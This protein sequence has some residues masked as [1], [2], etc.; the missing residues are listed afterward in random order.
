MNK[1]GD[2]IKF[3]VKEQGI[4]EAELSRRIGIAKPIINR[5]SNGINVNP[6]LETLMAIAGYFNITISQLL[7]QEPIK[8]KLNSSYSSA[9]RRKKKVPLISWADAAKLTSKKAISASDEY[10]LTESDV[11]GPLFALIAQGTAMEPRFPAKT[12]LIFST[13][14][15]LIDGGYVLV[16]LNNRKLPVFKQII[17]DGSNYFITSTNPALDDTAPLSNKDKIIGVLAQARYD[18]PVSHTAKEK[19]HPGVTFLEL[20]N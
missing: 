9:H 19:N 3:L 2:N 17:S 10:V 14:G 8:K 16:K 11:H 15:S 4:T 1:L 20:V 5:M 18:E 7:G 12:T 13:Q 6:K